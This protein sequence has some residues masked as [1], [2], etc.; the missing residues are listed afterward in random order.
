MSTTEI[1][2]L[3]PPFL[4]ASESSSLEQG[5][6][7]FFFQVLSSHALSTLGCRSGPK[8]LAGCQAQ[9]EDKNLLGGVGSVSGIGVVDKVWSGA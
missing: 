2:P 9:K 3:W 4:S 5:A 8:D 1:F 6:C 7:G